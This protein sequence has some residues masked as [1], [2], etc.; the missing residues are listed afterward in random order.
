MIRI[1]IGLLVMFGVA[2]GIDTA[3]DEELL[4]HLGL[5]IFA[6]GMMYSGVRAING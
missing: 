5:A 2:G 4:I 6:F 3:T 1:L